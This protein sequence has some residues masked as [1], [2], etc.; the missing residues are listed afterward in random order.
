MSRRGSEEEPPR[1]FENKYSD[2]TGDQILLAHDGKIEEKLA[3]RLVSGVDRL[4]S[5]LEAEY[6]LQSDPKDYSVYTG[7]AG[8]SLM[9][10]HL[11]LRLHTSSDKTTSK[12]LHKAKDYIDIS[13]KHLSNKPGRV[14]F[15]GGEAGPLAVAA[16][17]YHV[18]GQ[19]EKS[20]ECIARLV[21]MSDQVLS[22]ESLANEVLFGRAGY[23]F[24]L[25]FVKREVNKSAV[26]D[27]T[28]NEIIS[29]LMELGRQM[30]EREHSEAGLMFEWHDKK[31]LGAAHGLAG[32]VYILM[33]CADSLSSID[34]T[35]IRR[36]VDYLLTLRFPSGNCPS[37][38][39][40]QTDRLVHWC[41]GAPGWIY[42]FITAHKLFN[43]DKFLSAAVDCAEVVWRRGLLRKGYGLCHGTTG[44][45]YALLALY[46]HTKDLKHLYRALKFGDWCLDYG[47]HGCRIADRPYSLFEGMAGTIYFLTDLLNPSEAKLPAFQL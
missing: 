4:V 45:G 15:L 43:D 10:I 16:L 14:A 17:V 5:R 25:L 8:V 40:S 30:A 46:N 31:Y 33:Q 44:N 27:R 20:Q 22:D 1:E 41:H 9:Y 6:S 28:L 19:Q 21:G 47:K 26:E 35:L 11:H 7:T 18:I 36:T 3:A 13:L 2:Y 42:M 32:I 37:S 38:L 12:Y 29:R 34:L 39:G 23:L 24:S